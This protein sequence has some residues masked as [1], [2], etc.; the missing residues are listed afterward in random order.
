MDIKEKALDLFD[1][2]KEPAT[3]MACSLF[4]E[5]VAGTVIP[6]VMSS[7]LA[8]RQKRQER[9]FERF[10][11]E[12]KDRLITLEEK[13]IELK[14]DK[15]IEFKDK[16]FGLISDYA[17]DEVQE[18]K[19]QYIANGFVNAA[20]IQEL[21]EDFVLMYYDTLKEL[22]VLDI[23][24]LKFYY[25]RRYDYENTETYIDILHKFNI[26]NE[27]YNAIQE[28]L[29][30]LGLLTSKRDEKQD[31]LYN[32]I[33]LLQETFEKILKGNKVNNIRFKKLDKRDS[34]QISKFGREFVEFFSE[35][36]Q[37]D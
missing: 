10:M 25:S 6:G 18:E 28:R 15:F 23:G 26:E 13:L 8:Y 37:E 17:L 24:V 36:K 9:M 33:L 1:A 30:R 4:L 34:L 35:Y 19:I 27:Q 14:P 2:T 31:D 20:G 5:G 7:V 16:Y 12:M 21:S 22:R 29:L 11:L 3:E 32:N